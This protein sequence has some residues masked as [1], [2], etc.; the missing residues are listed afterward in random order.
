MRY[1]ILFLIILLFALCESSDDMDPNKVDKNS[2]PGNFIDADKDSLTYLALGDS[3]TIGTGVLQNERW[4]TQLVVSLHDDDVPI[5]NPIYIAANGWTTRNLLTAIEARELD[6][7]YNMISLLIGVNNQYQQL[8]FKVFKSE[9]RELLSICEQKV[10]TKSGLFV[11]SIPDYGVTP[12]GL[13]NEQKISLEID[14][15]NAWI[16]SICEQNQITFYNVTDISRKAK[17]NSKLLAADNLH[18]SASM[19]ALWVEEITADPPPL[20]K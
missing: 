4:P 5:K 18:P 7:S 13:R 8:D 17:N 20:L 9:F 2:A 16:R 1:T 3:Y 6:S 14:T 12:F 10:K 11:L 19:Y 15:Y